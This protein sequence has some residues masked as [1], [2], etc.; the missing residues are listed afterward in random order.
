MHIVHIHNNR[1]LYR[2]EV[3]NVKWNANLGIRD[4]YYMYFLP[5]VRR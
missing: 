4:E 1:I 5:R 3:G 2:V